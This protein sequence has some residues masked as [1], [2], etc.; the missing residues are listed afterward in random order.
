MS[1]ASIRGA[2]SSK[3]T[4][5]YSPLSSRVECL[6][7]LRFMGVHRE[8]EYAPD[9]SFRVRK[10]DRNGPK[11]PYMQHKRGCMTTPF[12]FPRQGIAVT[13][14][15]ALGAALYSTGE[16]THEASNFLGADHED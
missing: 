5:N 2:F 9:L 12:K 10:C 6:R 7:A 4:G 14:L 16:L 8:R 3:S 11:R 13:A 15:S 1:A